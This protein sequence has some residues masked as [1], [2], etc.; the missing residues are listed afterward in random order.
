MCVTLTWHGT[1]VKVLFLISISFVTLTSIACNNAGNNQNKHSITDTNRNVLS[2]SGYKSEIVMFQHHREF[3]EA[4]K[5]GDLDT[6]KWYLK[7]LAISSYLARIYINERDANSYTALML[8]AKNGHSEVVKLILDSNCP[9]FFTFRCAGEVGINLRGIS[10]S[11]AFTLASTHGHT[12]VVE[13]LLLHPDID[14]NIRNYQTG[15]T[16]LI[17]AVFY[18]Y[19]DVVSLLLSHPNIDVTIQN[20]AGETALDIALE[21]GYAEI[22]SM[23]REHNSNNLK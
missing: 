11:T 5:N 3:L 10:G 21:Q 2:G 20:R 23:I 13:M 4:A 9:S 7:S 14:V 22:I 12:E 18:N 15:W 1:V 19:V 8:A 16:A 6:V 17:G